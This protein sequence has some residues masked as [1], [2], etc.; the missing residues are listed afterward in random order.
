[1]PSDFF[2]AIPV[3]PYTSDE[4]WSVVD[5]LLAF[6]LRSIFNQSDSNFTAYIC[7]H[8]KPPC[9]DRV[10]FKQAKFLEATF[11]QPQTDKERR[12]DKRNKRLRIATE[13]RRRGGGYFMYLDADDLVHRSLVQ[14]VRKDDNRVGYLAPTGYALDFGNRRLAPIPGAW[15]KPFN[16]VCGSSGIL[17]YEPDDLPATETVTDAD[18]HRLYF[19]I[20]N[21][22]SFS[23]E[24]IRPGRRLQPIPFPS[25]IYTI[26]HPQNLSNRLVRTEERQ[27]DLIDSVRK[28][29]VPNV[30]EIAPDFA[31]D[32]FFPRSQ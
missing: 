31:L 4:Q 32:D 15:R 28:R 29:A 23:E 26:N 7:G 22:L 8:Q 17:F 9:L 11:P 10:E 1:M 30:H 24:D 19:R 27:R 12:R 6:T 20:R 2:F 5:A 21:H 16:E 14:H 13:V 18:V 25:V 3:A